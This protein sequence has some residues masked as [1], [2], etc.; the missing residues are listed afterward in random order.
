MMMLKTIIK[1]SAASST[2]AHALGAQGSSVLSRIIPASRL[3]STEP[4]KEENAQPAQ[5]AEPVA[6]PSQE[7]PER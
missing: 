7:K 1:K 5:T 3:F 6:T 4:P 2:A